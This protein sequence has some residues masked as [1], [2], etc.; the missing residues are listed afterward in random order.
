MQLAREAKVEVRKVDE[1]SGVRLARVHL[2]QQAPIF[3]IN[4]RQMAHDFG[5]A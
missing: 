3:A 5:E 2:A 4:A 1:D